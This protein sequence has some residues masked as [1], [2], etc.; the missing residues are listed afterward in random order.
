MATNQE[1]VNDIYETVFPRLWRSLCGDYL[2]FGYFT[3]ECKNMT[4][5]NEV[6]VDWIIKKLNITKS[7]KVLEI[8]CGR[9][10][11]AI[12]MSKQTGCS[13]VGIDILPRFIEEGK[14]MLVE[15]GVQDKGDV[16]VGDMTKLS[17]SLGD[18]K[19]TH[20]LLLG[21]LFYIHDQMDPFYEQLKQHCAPGTWVIAQD[22]TRTV[23][24][25]EIRPVMRHWRTEG[26]TL[27]TGTYINKISKAGFK[28]EYY[29]N[30]NNDNAIRSVNY[31]VD[32]GNKMVEEGEMPKD[33]FT[34]SVLRDAMEA[35]KM[36]YN[37]FIYR[38]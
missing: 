36:R 24:V 9:G 6:F 19:F 28:L 26:E 3:D 7:S 16:L 11:Y 10:A 2:N 37:T 5:A 31:I 1:G 18:Q 21:C 12:N 20:V 8:G 14:A 23:P 29:N 32:G 25:D 38:S 34:F 4:E 27:D 13:F 33:S 17:E 30:D 15:H 35:G 22:F